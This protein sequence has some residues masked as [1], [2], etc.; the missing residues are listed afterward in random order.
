M[1]MVQLRAAGEVLAEFERLLDQVDPVRSG[2]DAGTRLEW[3]RR[4]RHVQGR[5]N[6]LAALL[7]AEA[8]RVHASERATGTPM[9]SWLG[10]GEP[11]SRREAASAVHQARALA[12]HPEV[13]DAAARGEVG[14]GQARAM[15]RLLDGLAPQLQPEQ[16]AHAETFL[17]GLA[18]Q[19][20][21]D[22]L[23]KAGP[24][25]LAEVAPKEAD[26]LAE[27]TLQRQAEAAQRAR[28]LRLFREGGSV[29]FEGSLPRVDG[30]LLISLLDVHGEQLRRTAIESRD[31]ASLGPT[32]EQRRADALVSL[33]R[34]A[35]GAK[36]QPGLGVARVLV[37]LDYDALRRSASGAG[38]IGEDEL[39]SAGELRQL[40]CDA[41]LVPVVLGGAS[42]V[43]DVGR[44]Q[45]LVTSAI[46]TALILRDGGC[47]F[48]GCDIRPALCEAHHV[49]P[50]WEGG[51]TSLSNCVLLCH[52]HHG[53]VEPN[54]NGLRDQWQVRWASGG[55]PEFVPPARI[56]PERKPLQSRRH[57][58]TG[59][60]P[61][62][63]PPGAPPGAK[64]L[65]G[66]A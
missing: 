64:S 28:S 52:S 36:P 37:K 18:G 39:L 24:R 13:A 59:R 30:E 61:Q 62:G 14:V 32:P 25:V 31:P 63:A 42:E 48:P 1:V 17:L 26:E 15:T 19:L 2:L 54:R 33:L 45:R 60:P 8:D 58:A 16:Q 34:S 53:L 11:L 57:S 20:D 51:R 40:C 7:T 35:A 9:A 21:S 50:W 49:T 65:A 41:E 46:R 22:Q 43:L 27:T 6:T 3:V 38:L 12:A 44:K 5:V 56:D 29:R 23:S 47:A 66:A 10:M 4:A 55:L